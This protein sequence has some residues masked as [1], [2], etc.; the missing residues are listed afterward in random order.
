ME[1]GNLWRV[2]PSVA[3]RADNPFVQHAIL[4]ANCYRFASRIRAPFQ[5]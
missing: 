1:I 5:P 3:L 2:R 4:L